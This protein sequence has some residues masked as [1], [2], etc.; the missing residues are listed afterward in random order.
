MQ[1]GVRRRCNGGE[2]TLSAPMDTSLT[3]HCLPGG[4]HIVTGGM[5][6]GKFGEWNAFYGAWPMSMA[7]RRPQLLHHRQDIP[8][9]SLLNLYELHHPV[10][11]PALLQTSPLL[12]QFDKT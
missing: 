5:T 1:R 10:I 12:F 2:T 7:C 6:G 8:V 4:A 9:T 3:E 11:K